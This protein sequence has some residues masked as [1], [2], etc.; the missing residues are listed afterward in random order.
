M[1]PILTAASVLLA[2]SI[3]AGTP[4]GRCVAA[5]NAATK[6]LTSGS[7]TEEHTANWRAAEKHALTVCLAAG[8][9]IE[10]R[11]QAIVRWA[12]IL[13]DAPA[14]L[15]LLQKALGE[16]EATVG[17]DGQA[18]LPLIDRLAGLYSV[19]PSKRNDALALA[20]RGLQIRKLVFGETSPEVAEGLVLLGLHWAVDEMP[21]RNLP[22]AEEYL[23]EAAAV[24]EKACGSACTAF[25]SALSNLHAVVKSQPGRESDAA[26]IESQLMLIH[27]ATHPPGAN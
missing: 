7:P 8:V 16:T 20:Q 11:N 19:K 5:H 17:P 27:A 22:L 2:L 13:N 18:L 24:A 6:L 4:E 21:D 26:K 15:S 12:G 1:K 14:E 23:R 3:F 9:P 25:S 10:L